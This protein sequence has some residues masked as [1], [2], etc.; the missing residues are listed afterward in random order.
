MRFIKIIFLLT[1]ILL[2]TACSSK[3]VEDSRPA[4]IIYKDANDKF[5]KEKYSEAADLYNKVYFLHPGSKIATKSELMEGLSHFKAKKYEEA[6]IVLNNF[7]EYH[8]LNEDNAYA[9]YLKSL[10]HYAQISNVGKDQGKT[11]EAR[12][13]LKEVINR[14]P[15]TKYATNASLKLDLVNEHLAGKEME[16][17][18]YYLR[19]M[20]PLAA[21]NRFQNVVDNYN[22]TIHTQE[23]LHRL[24]EANLMLGLEKEAQKYAAILGNN[25][26]DSKWYKYS[27]KLLK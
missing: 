21:T 25:Y 10:A 24:V 23:A 22:F 6:I 9:Y 5:A 26:P 3:K 15:A 1:N 20:Q 4:E 19:M 8:P 14:F 17:G 12:D 18:L 16:I 7:I 2:V 13:A 11:I 27:Y